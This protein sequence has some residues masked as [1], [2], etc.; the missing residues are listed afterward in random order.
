MDLKEEILPLFE[1]EAMRKCIA[2]NYDELYYRIFWTIIDGARCN[3]HKKA[4][5][6]KAL[7]R[8]Q[9]ADEDDPYSELDT[10]IECYDFAIRNIDDTSPGDV[11]IVGEYK[12]DGSFENVGFSPFLS[13]EA[14][15]EYAT[16]DENCEDKVMT[17]E[18][19]VMT[20]EK[21]SVKSYDRDERK[22]YELIAEY[23]VSPTKEIWDFS[24]R[25]HK[26]GMYDLDHMSLPYPFKGG[27]IIKVDPTPFAP[28]RAAVIIEENQNPFSCCSPWV[29]YVDEFGDLDAGAL[30]HKAVT[31]HTFKNGWDVPSSLYRLELYT[32]E[33]PEDEQILLKVSEAYKN[34]PALGDDVI[35]YVLEREEADER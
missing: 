21:Y 33:L 1:S 34:N 16:D 30:K 11:F 14:A 4:E 18:D 5:L 29:A 28:V 22:R 23:L 19:K 25:E 8:L 35:K 3:I 27:D 12:A 24:C 7:P 13:F 10:M 9:F 20:I 31:R 6:L 15:F 32:D 17:C 2:E 26:F